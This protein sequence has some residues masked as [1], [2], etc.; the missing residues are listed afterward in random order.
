MGAG[1]LSH[2]RSVRAHHQVHNHPPP[3]QQISPTNHSVAWGWTNSLRVCVWG[4]CRS[5]P[6]TSSTP[7]VLHPAPSTLHPTPYT[8]HPTPYT[9]HPTPYTLNSRPSTQQE[10]S[11]IYGACRKTLIIFHS[12]AMHFTSKCVTL[13]TLKHICSKISCLKTGVLSYLRSV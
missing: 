7:Y 13:V 12:M 1:V 3:F 8:L 11:T 10:F 5:S 6:P 4:G 2:L 9:L